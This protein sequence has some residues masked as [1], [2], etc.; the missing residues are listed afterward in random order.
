M[1]LGRGRE[2]RAQRGGVVGVVRVTQDAPA[3]AQ[4]HWSMPRHQ[5]LERRGVT[6]GEKSLDEL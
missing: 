6:L 3:D 2:T 4:D 5:H 1:D